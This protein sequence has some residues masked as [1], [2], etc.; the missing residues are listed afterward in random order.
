MTLLITFSLPISASAAKPSGGGGGGGGTKFTAKVTVTPATGTINVNESLTLTATWSSNLGISSSQWS[1]NGNPIGSIQPLSNALRGQST[2]TFTPTSAGTYS[3][4]FK[5]WNDVTKISKTSAPVTVTV[6]Q[7]APSVIRYVSLGD[8]VATGTTSP[9]TADTNPYTDQYESYLKGKYPGATVVRSEFE[10]DGDRTN[11]LYD[12]LGLGDV[13]STASLDQNMIN[14][15]GQADVITLCIGGNNLMQ[16]CKKNNI[17]QPYDFFSPNLT[18][19][20]QGYTDF[21]SQYA[22]IMAK[23]DELDKAGAVVIVMTQ[24]NPYNITD[25]MHNLV[26]SYYFGDL[27]NPSDGMDDIITGLAG[28][29]NYRVADVFTEFD[30]YNT[31]MGAVTLLYPDIW[32]RNP[33]PNQTG[34]DKITVLH[35]NQY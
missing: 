3:L 1:L 19:A 2:Y 27:T 18:V 21:M 17:F 25:D 8:S 13:S 28:T 35:E 12:K 32:T 20:K 7:L 15:I 14:A 24:Y 10:T 22:K 6:N 31:N 29:Y 16:A 33:H 4:T 34:Q 11:E 5:I 26:D 30:R 23:I 9:L